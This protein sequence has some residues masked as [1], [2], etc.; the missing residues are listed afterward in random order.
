MK[1]DGS[2]FG[3]DGANEFAGNPQGLAID[4]FC[5]G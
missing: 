3:A 5:S 1:A 4:E 2:T